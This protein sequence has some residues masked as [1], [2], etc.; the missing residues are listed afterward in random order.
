LAR[1]HLLRP[2][3]LCRAHLSGLRLRGSSKASVLCLLRPLVERANA[4][5]HARLL[6]GLLSHL[7]GLLTL[8]NSLSKPRLLRCLL[9]HH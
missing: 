9:S 7:N 4:L 8:A 2:Y 5:L 1:P 6:S 3:L